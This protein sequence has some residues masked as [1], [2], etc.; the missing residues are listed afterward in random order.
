MASLM[1][2]MSSFGKASTFRFVP[3][4]ASPDFFARFLWLLVIFF[5]SSDKLRTRLSGR[6]GARCGKRGTST[7]FALRWG[8]RDGLTGAAEIINCRNF[9]QEERN[10]FVSSVVHLI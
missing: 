1:K 10:F 2:S 8:I 3:A 4:E 7:R 5:L 6:C 9:S